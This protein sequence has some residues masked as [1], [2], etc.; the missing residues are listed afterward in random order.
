MVEPRGYDMFG[1]KAVA[2]EIKRVTQ[3]IVGGDLEHF[4]EERSKLVDS[5][6]RGSKKPTSTARLHRPTVALGSAVLSPPASP[7]PTVETDPSDQH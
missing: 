6:A 2:R 1:N 4:F 3:G 5:V 7:K